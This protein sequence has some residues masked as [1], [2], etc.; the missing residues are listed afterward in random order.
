[1]SNLLPGWEIEPAKVVGSIAALIFYGRFYLQWYT[2]ERAGRSVVPVGFWYMSSVGSLL[3]FGYGVYEQSAVGTLA[4]CFN[5]FIYARNLIHIWRK[6]GTLS[7]ARSFLVHGIALAV[8]FIALGLLALTWLNVFQATRA[9]GEEEATRTWFWIAIGVAGQGLFACRFIVQ[10]L[11][12]E[13]KK[14][15]VIPVSFWYFSVVAAALMFASFLQL[16]EWIF[17]A[18]IATTL[19][20]YARNLWIIHRGKQTHTESA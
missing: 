4:H 15:S 11:T 12:T 5:L 1:M 16:R 9:G 14:E 8:V 18:G 10:W 3:L 20:I 2:S 7:Q 19:P 13:K 17:A 6:K